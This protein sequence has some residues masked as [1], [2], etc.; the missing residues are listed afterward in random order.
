MIVGMEWDE[1]PMSFEPS[2][3]V[4]AHF[5]RF[6]KLTRKEPE[7]GHHIFFMVSGACEETRNYLR[8]AVY[9]PVSLDGRTDVGTNISKHEALEFLR[10][11]ERGVR[12]LQYRVIE[13]LH[14]RASHGSR[15]VDESSCIVAIS[16]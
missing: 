7:K 2:V 1:V 6:C 3:L 12:M 4:L 16:C 10:R 13:G 11:K 5:D 9:L 14:R 15:L 8:L